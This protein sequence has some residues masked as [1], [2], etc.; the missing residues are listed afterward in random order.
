VVVQEPVVEEPVVEEPV[1]EEPVVE[2]PV[3]VQEPVEKWELY[4]MDGCPFCKSA[5]EFLEKRIQGKDGAVL[6][7][8]VGAED[9][10]VVNKFKSLGDSWPKIFLNGNFIGGY[11]DLER[12][13]K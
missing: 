11:S 12:D 7:V 3:V 6:D 4:T 2:E 5:K 8:K 9:P 10:I 1:V 13:Y